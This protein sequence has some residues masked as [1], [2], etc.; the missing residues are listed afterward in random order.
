MHYSVSW[1][2]GDILYVHVIKLLKNFSDNF[3]LVEFDFDKAQHPYRFEA[4]FRVNQ[5]SHDCSYPSMPTVEKGSNFSYPKLFLSHVA[6]DCADLRF[7]SPHT[8]TNVRCKT[9]DTG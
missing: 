9:S 7:S 6:H 5:L 8:Y 2:T 4:T 1:K 3:F